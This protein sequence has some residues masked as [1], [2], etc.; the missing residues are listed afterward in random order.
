MERDLELVFE[1]Y[2]WLKL[3][4]NPCYE[5]EC[6]RIQHLLTPELPYKPSVVRKLF[7]KI[8]RNT[9]PKHDG[10]GSSQPEKIGMIT[11]LGM[12]SFRTMFSAT[13][14]NQSVIR[15]TARNTFRQ[16]WTKSNCAIS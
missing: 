12:A 7:I 8:R 9:P 13:D 4:V 2:R 6:I 1:L 10:G 3:N 16:V 15:V 5:P 14:P 11:S